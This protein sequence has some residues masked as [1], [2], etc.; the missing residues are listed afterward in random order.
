MTRVTRWVAICMLLAVASMAAPV[1]AQVAATPYT[2][3]IVTGTCDAPGDVVAPMTAL[4]AP[5]GEPA[6]AGSAI[7]GASSYSSVAVS[8]DDLLAAPHAISVTSTG[9]NAVVSCGDIGGVRNDGGALV[10]GLRPLNGSGLAGIAYLSPQAGNPAQTGISTFL[11]ATSGGNTSTG[12]P[13]DETAYATTVRSHITLVVGSLQRV[14]ALFDQPRLDDQAWLN[15]VRAE[16][17]LWQ[18]IYGE[19]QDLVPPANLAAFH[20]RYVEAI[21]LLDSAAQDIITGLE[22]NDQALLDQADGKINDAVAAIRAL[23][24]ADGATPGPASPVPGT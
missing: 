19:A 6:G 24:S 13:L 21:A 10:I 22:T 5:A 9:D 7:A 15:Q 4:E 20:G 3:Q 16:L 11:A 18:V 1:A 17:T 14:D 12:D 8:I 2:L 23:D